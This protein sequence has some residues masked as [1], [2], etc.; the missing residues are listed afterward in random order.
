MATKVELIV[1]TNLSAIDTAFTRSQKTINALN[2][3]TQTFGRTLNQGFKTVNKEAQKFSR[4]IQKGN[5]DLKDMGVA[6]A[7]AGRAGGMQQLTNETKNVAK[8]ASQAKKEVSTLGEEI[9]R[10]AV[11]FTAGSLINAGIGKIGQA[12]SDAIN[13]QREFE[14]SVQNLSAITGAGGTD[15]QFYSDEAIRLGSTIKG[16]ASAAVEAFKLIGSAKPELL[17]NK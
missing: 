11:G 7:G 1:D 5:K 6:A 4:E 9:K 12:F 16:G 15:L 2:K 3:E 14:K 10:M 8:A 13:V 17:Q